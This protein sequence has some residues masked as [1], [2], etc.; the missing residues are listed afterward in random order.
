MLSHTCSYQ[1]ISKILKFNIKTIE[2]AKAFNNEINIIKNYEN[3]IKFI[4]PISASFYPQS[5]EGDQ[6]YLEL[7]HIL[8]Y[9]IY[10]PKRD[11]ELWK[12]CDENLIFRNKMKNS[13]K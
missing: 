5:K 8:G 6:L 13:K 4:A 12:L 7:L 10:E 9:I 3:N 1:Y 11:C 2:F